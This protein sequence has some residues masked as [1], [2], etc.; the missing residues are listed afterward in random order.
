MLELRP[1]WPQLEDLRRPQR[2]RERR[3]RRRAEAVRG[4]AAGGRCAS[5]EELQHGVPV[6]VGV[7]LLRGGRGRGCRRVQ[8]VVVRVVVVVAGLGGGEPGED[9]PRVPVRRTHG[10]GSREEER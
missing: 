5:Q 1:Q 8:L 10:Q 4:A 3:R 9:G 6:V 7:G 2:P